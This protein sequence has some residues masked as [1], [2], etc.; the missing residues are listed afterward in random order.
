MTGKPYRGGPA[1]GRH[2]SPIQSNPKIHPLLKYFLGRLWGVNPS[3]TRYENYEQML[4]DLE[5]IRN[6]LADQPDWTGLSG[7]PQ[8]PPLDSPAPHDSDTVSRSL[9]HRTLQGMAVARRL[10]AGR[11]G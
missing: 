9:L 6:R 4:R 8:G 2:F 1:Y 5:R 3:H 11:E 10:W 7:R